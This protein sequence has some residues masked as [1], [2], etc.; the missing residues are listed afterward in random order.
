MIEKLF[1]QLSKD[2]L[3]GISKVQR[4]VEQT[5]PL[6]ERFKRKLPQDVR[7]LSHLLTDER[8]ARDDGYMGRDQALSAY[9]RYFLPWNLYRLTR[10]LPQ[11][12]VKL[13]A[14][15]AITDIGSGPLTFALAL[16]IS[17]PELRSV[18]LEFRCLDRSGKALD[19]GRAIFQE[20]APES[21]WTLR[22]IRGPIGTRIDGAPAALLVAANVLN[23]LFWDAKESVSVQAGKHARQM[24]ALTREEEG[25]AKHAERAGRILIVEPGIPRSAEYI[26]ALRGRFLEA[27]AAA[28]A[29]CTHSR[30]CPAP[31]GKTARSSAKWCH[32]AFEC[33]DAPEA[34]R[35]LSAAAGIP[36]D[37][38][39]LSFLYIDSRPGSASSA[40]GSASSAAG[41]A[42]SAAGS[43]S[44]AAGSASSAAGSS[45]S[46]AAVT[47]SA[48]LNEAAPD[49]SERLAARVISDSFP[50][51]N[52]R[53]ARYAC[54]EPGLLLISG[55]S[56]EI[57]AAE[58]GAKLSL[59]P[60]LSDGSRDPKSRAIIV[61]LS[62]PQSGALPF[63][64]RDEQGIA[65][66]RNNADRGRSERG[67]TA[68]RNRDAGG[69]Q[70]RGR[71][72]SGKPDFNKPERPRTQ[73]QEQPGFSGPARSGHSTRSSAA[74]KRPPRKR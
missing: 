9:L 74:P 3:K 25:A 51:P 19:A 28:L 55:E 1:P 14:G 61:P 35:R 73:R 62:A 20:L 69:R 17:R 39:T 57:L 26:A 65:S 2:C 38:A 60:T 15:D 48:T 11:L 50:L 21:P 68:E 44:S 16:Y 42:S 34:L 53:Y 41:S 56:R 72:S 8:S 13:A 5:Y 70:V 45:S 31:G 37:R 59:D 46:A 6:P 67:N 27:G 36:K 7:Q 24:M 54:A 29:P 33:E 10:L 64:S 52:R 47:S 43:A 63:D 4:I 49:Q 32:F 40:S 58:S 30:Q 22:C 66:P 18:P 23:E 12:D 71:A